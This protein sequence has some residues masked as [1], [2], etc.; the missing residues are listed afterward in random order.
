MIV[1]LK[2]PSPSSMHPHS[3]PSGTL[4]QHCRGDMSGSTQLNKA[5]QSSLS[6]PAACTASMGSAQ[7]CFNAV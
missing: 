3:L 1:H 7:G 5:L 2:S 6:P 4:L